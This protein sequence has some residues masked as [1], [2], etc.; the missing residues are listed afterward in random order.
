MTDTEKQTIVDLRE[1]GLP[2]SEIADTLGLSGNTVKSYHRREMKKRE[3]ALE[4]EKS[5]EFHFCL[6]CGKKLRQTPKQKRRRYCNAQCRNDYWNRNRDAIN[7]KTP[8]RIACAYCRKEFDTHGRQN[9]KYCCR[10]CYACAR[11]GPPHVGSAV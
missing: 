3:L 7:H 11:W 6:H 8:R 1:Q 10:E 9:R 5:T 2:F 4:L